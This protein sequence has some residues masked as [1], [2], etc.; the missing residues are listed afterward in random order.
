MLYQ[1][2]CTRCDPQRRFPF[3]RGMTLAQYEAERRYTFARLRC[4]RCGRRRCI[5]PDVRGSG[6]AKRAYTFPENAPDEI[7]GRSVLCESE[8]QALLK[9]HGLKESG[10]EGKRADRHTRTF[11]VAEIRAHWAETALVTPEKQCA[12]DEVTVDTTPLVVPT[13]EAVGTPAPAPAAHDDSRPAAR[14]HALKAQA[15]RLG[16]K[17]TSRTK[18]RELTRLVRARIKELAEQ[19]A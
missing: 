14:W 15:K 11:K 2:E 7:A 12:E 5:H 19:G 13:I 18:K 4:P 16:L 6:L 1:F 17:I 9:K 8:K 3:T 10:K